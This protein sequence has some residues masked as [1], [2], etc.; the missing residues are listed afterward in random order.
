MNRLNGIIRAIAHN[1]TLS[2]VDVEAVGLVFSAT[3]LETPMTAGY[4]RIGTKV[5]LLFKETEVSLARDLTGEISIRNRFGVT[6]T[7]IEPGA[8]LSAVRLDCA[9]LALTS[10]IT[11]R[12]VQRLNIRAG[13]R[14]E[15]LVK[16]NEMALMEG[17]HGG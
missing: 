15:A 1:D 8:I 2:L 4:L 6:V 9:G 5:T 13:D 16:A 3:L 12:A 14:L 10:V 17:H 11:T 7:A